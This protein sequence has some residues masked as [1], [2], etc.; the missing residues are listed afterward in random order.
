[1]SAKQNK[2]SH[3]P[4]TH[5][6]LLSRPPCRYGVAFKW[7]KGEEGQDEGTGAA[8]CAAAAQKHLSAV[9][10]GAGP[11][12]NRVLASFIPKAPLWGMAAATQQA[13][14][15]GSP[16]LLHLLG[17]HAQGSLERN[18]AHLLANP[19]HRCWFQRQQGGERG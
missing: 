12:G 2:Q 9:A 3:P 16:A 5:T 13:A 7:E 15:G 4:A 1:M 17:C 8:D 6:C 10:A 11:V 14:A 18:L 19:M